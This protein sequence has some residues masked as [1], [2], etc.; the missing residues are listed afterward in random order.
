MGYGRNNSSRR[1]GSRTIGKIVRLII[2]IIIVIWSICDLPGWLNFSQNTLTPLAFDMAEKK[3][4]RRMKWIQPILNSL[5]EIID[6][7]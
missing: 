4:E 1:K 5:K 2:G 6:N 3:A 7:I